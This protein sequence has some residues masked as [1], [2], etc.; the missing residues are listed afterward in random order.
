MDSVKIREREKTRSRK[1]RNGNC[2]L[3][4]NNEVSGV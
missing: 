2:V 4:K 3:L 1:G